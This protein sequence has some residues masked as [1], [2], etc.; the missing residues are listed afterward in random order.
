M[1]CMT[2]PW[3][4]CREGIFEIDEFDCTEIFVVVGNER[5]LVIDT[6]TGI[7]DLKGLIERKITDKPYIVA[8]SH[9][10]GDHIGGAGWFSPIFIH[11]KD[12]D[13]NT[14]GVVPTLEFRKNYANMI[15]H[16]ENKH[17]AYDPDTDI[18]EWPQ[19]P[20]FLP[21]EDG[22]RFE[23][24]GRTVTAYHCP[25][26][27]AGEMVFLDDK[28]GTLLCGDAFNC[29]WLLNTG[30]ATTPRESAQI[31]LN[32]MERIYAMRDRYNSVFNFHHDFRGFGQPLSP[33]VI[34]NLIT[35]LRQLLE[36][37]ASFRQEADG[38]N[39]GKTKTVAYVNNVF[40]S[41]MGY[42][43]RALSEA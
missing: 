39:P 18:R 21:M 1:A 4:E 33:D 41:C 37:K 43:I 16:R 31:A 3:F 24:G 5:A 35:C 25:G 8:A 15:T 40:I 36:S 11:S 2:M 10:H 12:M 9:N 26:H 32:A 34:P 23:L 29:N 38:L 27:T 28:T 30:I 13:W 22:H 14:S 7:G 42:D 17:Y 20:E 6:G 19:T